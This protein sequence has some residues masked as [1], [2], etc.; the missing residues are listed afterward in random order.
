MCDKGMPA[1]ERAVLYLSTPYWLASPPNSSWSDGEG[2]REQEV[3]LSAAW[4]GLVCDVSP[5][6]MALG[7]GSVH[8]IGT[9][10][11]L[12]CPFPR[13]K[14]SRALAGVVR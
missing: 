7:Y 5:V 10:F 1:S 3:V 12:T 6:D 8:I 11:G 14:G 2:R 9:A 4:Q 13:F